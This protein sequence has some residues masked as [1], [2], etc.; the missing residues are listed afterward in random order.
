EGS[1]PACPPAQ[2]RPPLLPIL[3]SRFFIK[4]PFLIRT[5]PR[6]GDAIV[7]DDRDASK[8]KLDF[9]LHR[10]DGLLRPRKPVR[11]MDKEMADARVGKRVPGTNRIRSYDLA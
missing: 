5:A 1:P 3:M 9:H 2:P 6:F 8:E 11:Q 4:N 7:E 10:D